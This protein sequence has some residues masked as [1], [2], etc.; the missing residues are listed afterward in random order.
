[1]PPARRA[2]GR[3]PG[4][5]IDRAVADATPALLGEVGCARL[6]IG[7]VPERAAVYRPTIYRRWPSEQH[8][9]TDV[10]AGALGVTPRPDTAEA[11][12]SVVQGA[13]Q[14]VANH[15]SASRATSSGRS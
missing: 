6:S 11:A 12:R 7:Q 9:V 1:M 2:A 13:P 3:Q 5:E 14:A 8:L 10:L 15:S 4:P